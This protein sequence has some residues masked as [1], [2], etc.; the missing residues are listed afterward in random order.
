[1]DLLHR[2]LA[3]LR[4]L[5]CFSSVHAAALQ[6]HHLARWLECAVTVLPGEQRGE[7]LQLVNA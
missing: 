5:L 6:P 4:A 2:A 7:L 1:M 3:I